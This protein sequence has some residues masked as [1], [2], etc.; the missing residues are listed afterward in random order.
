MTI[1]MTK[2]LGALAAS[3]AA[4]GVPP[5]MAA[6]HQRDHSGMFFAEADTKRTFG[7]DLLNL[8]LA[9]GRGQRQEGRAGRVRL[10]AGDAQALVRPAH[11]RLEYRMTVDKAEAEALELVLAG[12]ESTA[13][14]KPACAH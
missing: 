4:W 2:R 6:L 3:A 13:V 10:D 7:G 9:S 14:V 8:A 11:V 1:R 5:G 12:C